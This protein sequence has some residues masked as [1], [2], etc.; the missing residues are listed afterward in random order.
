MYRIIEVPAEAA[1]STEQ[2]G[3]KPKFWFLDPSGQRF[4]F[5]QGR[6]GTGENWAEKVSAVAVYDCETPR[7][8]FHAATGSGA[9]CAA[10]TAA[11]VW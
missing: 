7:C 9:S 11:G 3:S 1:D 5:K 4:L 6:S 2:L 8:G 10:L